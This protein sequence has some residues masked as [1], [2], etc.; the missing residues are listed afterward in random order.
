MTACQPTEQ[1]TRTHTH[2]APYTSNGRHVLHT[3]C[4]RLAKGGGAREDV[5]G[6]MGGL[7]GGEGQ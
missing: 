1:Q 4:I 3:I 2:A 7:E 6:F 5:G